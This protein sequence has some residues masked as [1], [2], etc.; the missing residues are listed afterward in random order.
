MWLLL[1]TARYSSF[2]A[3]GQITTTIAHLLARPQQSGPAHP[4]LLERVLTIAPE[5]TLVNWDASLREIGQLPFG[6]ESF[7][8]RNL[9]APAATPT[10]AATGASSSDVA[11]GEVKKSLNKGEKLRLALGGCRFR[12]LTPVGSESPAAGRRRRRRVYHCRKRPGSRMIRR[13]T[14]RKVSPASS[15]TIPLLLLALLPQRTRQAPRA[16]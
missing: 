10:A 1:L 6:Y 5:A 3:S 16:W 7:N 13:A 8:H 9:D 4:P 11:T 2:T 14:G 15:E 12:A